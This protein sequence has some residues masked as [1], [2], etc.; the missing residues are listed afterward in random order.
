MPTMSVAPAASACRMASAIEVAVNTRVAVKLTRQLVRPPLAAAV[1]ARPLPGRRP[2]RPVPVPVVAAAAR[3]V[4][5]RRPRRAG[6]A[7]VA[8]APV[9]A[10]AAVRRRRRPLPVVLAA[11]VAVVE[12]GR[13]PRRPVPVPVAAAG[14]A[15]AAARGRRPRRAP[16]VPV[17]LAAADVV[18]AAARGR[19]PRRA[20]VVPP[21]AAPLVLVR[22]RSLAPCRCATRYTDDSP[23]PNRLLISDTGVSVS[24][25]R[26]VTS[27]SWSS[28]SLR[29]VPVAPSPDPRAS[30]PACERVS[31]SV[32]TTLQFSPSV[33]RY[34]MR[35]R[36]TTG[37]CQDLPRVAVRARFWSSRWQSTKQLT[38]V[39]SGQ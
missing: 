30:A 33:E 39:H 21:L 19:R 17:P 18:A 10:V 16:V 26:R 25:Y 20:P 38:G 8:A 4:P 22:P 27:R 11:L 5:G 9:A 36:G 3:P 31:V 2:R 23:I 6:V 29:R 15:A 28:V 7:A 14:V 35:T 13:R 1:A 32:I 37:G 12:P 24:A 34:C